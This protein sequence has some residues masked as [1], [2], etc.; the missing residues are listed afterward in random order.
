MPLEEPSTMEEG[1]G[2]EMEDWVGNCL[3]KKRKGDFQS[4]LDTYK[5]GRVEKSPEVN[6]KMTKTFSEMS[7][8][9]KLTSSTKKSIKKQLQKIKSKRS[10]SSRRGTASNL[11]N[12]L[13]R[14]TDQEI[15]ISEVSSALLKQKSKKKNQGSSTLKSFSSFQ[16]SV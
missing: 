4:V 3:V 11:K 6:K 14:L 9:F 7:P 5:K 15:K 13:N 16:S 8:C 2:L 1:E 10:P 12:N